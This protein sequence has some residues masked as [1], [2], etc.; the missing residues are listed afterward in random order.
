[1]DETSYGNLF[2]IDASVFGAVGEGGLRPVAAETRH[3]ERTL[4]VVILPICMR[5]VSGFLCDLNGVPKHLA[6]GL[7]TILL[8]SPEHWR[9]QF[10]LV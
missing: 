2:A 3:N 7:F 8:F 5:I 10:C 6:R 4:F 9:P 1:M